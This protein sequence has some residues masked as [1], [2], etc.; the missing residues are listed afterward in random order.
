MNTK[1][2][3]SPKIHADLLIRWTFQRGPL[4]RRDFRLPGRDIQSQNT[5]LLRVRIGG[6]EP[7]A[8]RLARMEIERDNL[9][10]PRA[11]PFK[12]P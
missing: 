4:G 3:P 12:G 1:S 9:Q 11:D 10:P 7:K 8:P 6:Q 5:C 2:R